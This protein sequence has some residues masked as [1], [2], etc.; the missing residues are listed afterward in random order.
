M[1]MMR[2]KDGLPKFPTPVVVVG[3]RKREDG[4]TCS[5]CVAHLEK[6]YHF[7]SFDSKVVTTISS[8]IR[9]FGIYFSS[10]MV[11]DISHA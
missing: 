2:K 4:E 7:L 8:R 10:I 3:Y 9:L 6:G 1:S 11:G 5:A